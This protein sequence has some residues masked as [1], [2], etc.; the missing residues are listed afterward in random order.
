MQPNY[1]IEQCC[2]SRI[3]LKH[4]KGDYGET[5]LKKNGLKDSFLVKFVARLKGGRPVELDQ[6]YSKAE[7]GSHWYNIACGYADA[8]EIDLLARI[9]CDKARA[10]F[11]LNEI[12]CLNSDIIIDA[13]KIYFDHPYTDK[14]H[15]SNKKVLLFNSIIAEFFIPMQRIIIKNWFTRDKDKHCRFKF[16]CY[17][18]WMWDND[19]RLQ[20]GVRFH[21][22][23]L[24]Y[25]LEGMG[26]NSCVIDRSSPIDVH[27]LK[28]LCADLR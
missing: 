5:I 8:G 11:M 10:V 23:G 17:E 12:P 27:G 25:D 16:K 3:A 14:I 2:S 13:K 26:E 18:D 28:K 6:T 19:I 21:I 22:G 15:R 4:S 24:W 1:D 7:L 20:D 9:L